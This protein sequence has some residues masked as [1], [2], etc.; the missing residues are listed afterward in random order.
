MIRALLNG[1]MM[2]WLYQTVCMLP[3]IIIGFSLHEFA[4]AWVADRCGDGTP[5]AMG[6]LTVDPRAHM[7]LLGLASLVF[8]HFGWGKPVEVNPYN[9][10]NRRRDGVFVA[11]AG[12][13]M[14]FIIATAL[15]L[16]F[17]IS[18]RTNFTANF[19]VLNPAGNIIL[20]IWL[21]M[22]LINYGLM[23]FNLLPVPPLDGFNIIS[24]LFD[25]RGGQLWTLVY[26]NS[27]II[28][29]LLIVLDIPGF[30]LS[31]PLTF[32]VELVCFGSV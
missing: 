14:N 7:D 8:I 16:L 9:F 21:N 31:K 13:T 1:G 30:L 5:R 2:D 17:Q 32:L 4:H 6:R 19:L 27:M 18:I 24:D 26:R 28:I 25:L 3:G 23:L 10:K 20:D 29:I 11:I 12:V 15:G 22:V